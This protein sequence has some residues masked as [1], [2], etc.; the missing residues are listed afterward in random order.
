MTITPEELE[1]I[2]DNLFGA[3]AARP[4]ITHSLSREEWQRLRTAILRAA[5]RLR[6]ADKLIRSLCRDSG[7]RFE[8]ERNRE[9]DELLKEWRRTEREEGEAVSN[10]RICRYCAWYEFV[11]VRFTGIP[12]AHRCYANNRESNPVTG[13]QVRDASAARMDESDCGSAGR[14]WK[15]RERRE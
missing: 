8:S 2:A 12:P 3:A 9:I 14:W 5:A 7:T 11:D 13:S 1:G 4:H 10:K 15:R 6:L